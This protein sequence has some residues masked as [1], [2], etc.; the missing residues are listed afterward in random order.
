MANKRPI[1][2]NAQ[3]LEFATR[4]WDLVHG[5]ISNYNQPSKTI[6]IHGRGQAKVPIYAGIILVNPQSESTR[7]VEL[8]LYS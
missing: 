8:T 2:G 7:I 3:T 1:S 6:Y 4:Q 5:T